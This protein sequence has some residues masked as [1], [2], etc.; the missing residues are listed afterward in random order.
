[1]IIS[2]KV[3][4]A[5]PR[6]AGGENH[7]GRDEH[8]RRRGAEVGLEQDQSGEDREDE[9]ERQQRRRQFVDALFFAARGTT[10]GRG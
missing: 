8:E 5:H 3:D 7:P 9:R 2:A 1:M 6:N 4:D 10:R